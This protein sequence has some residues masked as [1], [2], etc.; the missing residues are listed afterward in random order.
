MTRETNM[1]VGTRNGAGH[2]HLP[3]AGDRKTT[4]TERKR[5]LRLLATSKSGTLLVCATVL[6]GRSCCWSTIRSVVN[7]SAKMSIHEGCDIE[8]ARTSETPSA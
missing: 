3:L 2:G 6:G 8:T 5:Y 7:C 1:A 4:K